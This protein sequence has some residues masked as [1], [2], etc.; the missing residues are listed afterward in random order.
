MKKERSLQPVAVWLLVGVGMIIVQ[1]LLGGIT[2]LTGSGLSI[3]EWK[4]ILGAIPPLTEQDWQAAFGKYQQIA[5]YKHLNSHFS[6]SDFKFIYF[7]E[8]FHRVW[9]RLLGVVF[10]IPFVV[11]WVQGR[12]KKSMIWPLVILF[13]LG[14]IQ[15][16]IGWIMV[17]SGLNDEDLYVSHFR[18]A[19][20]FMAAMLLLVYTF[21]FAL[22]LLVPARSFVS[23]NMLRKFTVWLIV[24]L[25]V[26]LVYG[27]FMAGLKAGAF[28]PTWPDING[29]MIPENMSS[30]RGREFS[31]LAAITNH[32]IA[33]HFVH[34]GL[35][36]LL[37]ALVIFW[38]VKVAKE[39]GSTLLNRI[40]WMPLVLVLVQVYLG[41]MS[42]LTSIKA[43]RQ[44]WGV[45]EWNAQLHQLV[46]MFL[47]L[48]L[49]FALYLLK[50]KR[51]F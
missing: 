26:Q 30:F 28:A 15:G 2:R 23:N 12:F 31:F 29:A 39:K 46:A 40:K 11:F 1:I 50:P 7:W 45:F 18:L 38:T 22:K 47:L 44:G 36:Y 42:A 21:W 14:G 24:L 43:V 10:F 32:P 37:V 51:G 25:S 49:T 33:I 48:S 5:Q 4:P 35:A 20:H 16:L 41:I 13:F 8:W 27:A 34:R 3:T 19:I 6:L 9:G 17:K